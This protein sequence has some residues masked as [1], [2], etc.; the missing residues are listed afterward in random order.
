MRHRSGQDFLAE[1]FR[2]AKET[3]AF[4]GPGINGKLWKEAN[5]RCYP[6]GP[7]DVRGHRHDQTAA[8]VIAW[9][10]GMK[11]TNPPDVF[12]YGKAGD[13]NHDPRTILLADGDY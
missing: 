12:A 8:S 2:L 9:R 11:L 7:A 6:C 13:S 1:Y 5:P 4:C 3:K 10:L